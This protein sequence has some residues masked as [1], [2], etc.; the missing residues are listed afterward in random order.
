MRKAFTL[1]EVLIVVTVVALLALVAVPNFAEAENRSRVSRVKTDFRALAV[2]IESYI[3]DRGVQPRE[4]NT[5]W[6]GTGDQLTNSSG[7]MSNVSQLMSNV[8]STPV[9]YLS[10]ARLIDL[11][12]AQGAP[13]DEQYYT[14]TDM[15]TRRQRYPTSGFWQVAPEYYGRWRLLSVGPDRRF[16]HGFSTS[17][18]LAYDPTNGA[19]SLGNIFRSEFRADSAQPD[20]GRSY[21][22]GSTSAVLLPLH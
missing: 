3:A 13:A 22:N 10:K 2:A 16:A 4:M 15:I 12:R 11:Y 9:P 6:Y 14:Y 17:A 1:V 19:Y 8:L 21:S 7:Q 18:Q 20:P 5:S